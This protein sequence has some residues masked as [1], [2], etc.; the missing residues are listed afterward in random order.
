MSTISWNEVY[1]MRDWFTVKVTTGS[2]GGG[3]LSF[4]D[5]EGDPAVIDPTNDADGTS[6]YAARRDHKHRISMPDIINSAP[7]ED[8]HDGSEWMY[9]SSA[10]LRRKTLWETIKSVLKT[11]FDTLYAV[12]ASGVTG[13]DSH[14]HS[15]GDGAQ[16]NHTTLSNIGTNT[17]SAIDDHI[18]STANPHSVTADQAGAIPS[19]GW[20]EVSDS[21]S[22]ASAN[23]IT[24][25]S[26]ATNIYNKGFVLRL[27]QGGDYKYFYITGVAS[28][29]LTVTGGSNYTVAN[30]AITD[31]AY[32]LA[33]NAIGFP[34]TFNLAA[35][36]WDTTTIDNGTGGQQPTAGSQYFSVD[37]DKIELSVVLGGSGAVKN[38]TA[39]LIAFAIPATLPS[40]SEPTLV[41]LGPAYTVANSVG[42][43][44]VCLANGT[45]NINLRYQSAITDNHTVP[46]TGCKAVYKY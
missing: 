44:G 32:S 18:A 27:K 7:S 13:G 22:Y 5:A 34:V 31:I 25:P 11:Y 8:P 14:D 30:A 4:N 42:L 6:A 20:I 37:G 3:G 24:V 16:I 1:D 28:T 21:W 33:R 10:G 41:P 43:V 19:N 15:G 29:L 38:G 39:S 12:T 23:T 46:F 35:P 45:A 36:T 2:S 26:D 17:H 40:I 9:R